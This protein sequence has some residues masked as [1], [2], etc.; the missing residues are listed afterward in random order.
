MI[1]LKKN[2]AFIIEYMNALSGQQKTREKLEQYNADPRLIE[3]IM[4]IDSVFPK[5]EVFIEEMLAEDD[6]VIVRVR[7]RGMHQGELMGFPPTHKWVEYPFVVRYQIKNNKI[8]HSWVIADN[9]VLA[10]AVG[11]KGIPPKSAQ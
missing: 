8:V 3:Y 7:F 4:F 9:L 11:M 2:K 10:E 5:Y 1:Q 6:K